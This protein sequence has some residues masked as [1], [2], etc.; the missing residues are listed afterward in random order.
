MP[1]ST[2]VPLGG[3]RGQIGP[4]RPPQGRPNNREAME[5]H[6]HHIESLIALGY[7]QR[8]TFKLE[9]QKMDMTGMLK[10]SG[11]VRQ[12]Y[13]SHAMREP[14]A[15]YGTHDMSRKMVAVVSRPSEM[16]AWEELIRAF[17]STNSPPNSQGGANGR[18]LV[19]SEP[20]R[21]SAAAVSR[22]SP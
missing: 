4:G 5:R 19:G 13:A 20:N 12:A 10:L 2:I 14:L 16:T 22:R 3:F 21:T 9:Q 11:L 7:L 8:R 6:D 17:D 15:Q 18:Q 1:S